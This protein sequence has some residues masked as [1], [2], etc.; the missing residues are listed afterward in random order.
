MDEYDAGE[1]F[2]EGLDSIVLGNH[3][4]IGLGDECFYMTSALM[5]MRG[6]CQRMM[7]NMISI[8]GLT[9]EFKVGP[10]L[11]GKDKFPEMRPRREW[12]RSYQ[13]TRV[14]FS[15]KGQHN[16]CVPVIKMNTKFSNDVNN[17]YAGNQATDKCSILPSGYNTNA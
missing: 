2:F 16:R 14:K 15:A 10:V 13:G 3:W 6:I 1:N 11:K 7:V 17:E 5:H 9:T 4:L 12:I 8:G